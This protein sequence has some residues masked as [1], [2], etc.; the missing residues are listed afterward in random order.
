MRDAVEPYLVGFR[1]G[2]RVYDAIMAHSGS[3]P[4]DDGRRLLR[5]CAR[6]CSGGCA[7]WRLNRLKGFDYSFYQCIHTHL[8]REEVLHEGGFLTIQFC[9]FSFVGS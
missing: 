1:H 4:T 2:L 5:K 7:S 8:S 6:L 3:V 9:I